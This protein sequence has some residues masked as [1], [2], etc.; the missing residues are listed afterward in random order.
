MVDEV[1]NGRMASTTLLSIRIDLLLLIRRDNA[2]IS[3][4]HYD[5]L[6]CSDVARNRNFHLLIIT[7]D[8]LLCIVK[9]VFVIG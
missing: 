9:L 2:L 4:G 8:L 3:I 6:H 7:D 5:A 1:A